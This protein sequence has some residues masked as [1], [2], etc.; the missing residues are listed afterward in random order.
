MDTTRFY[1]DLVRIPEKL[2]ALAGLVRAG[3]PGLDRL[4][5][6][7]RILIVAMGSSAYAAET[8]ARDARAAGM[9]VTVEL[10]SAT[11]LPK[12]APDLLVIAV[13]ATGGSVEVLAAAAPYAGTGRL[14]AITNRADSALA[15]LADH[16]VELAAGVEVSGISARTFRHTFIVLA[17]VLIAL[18]AEFSWSPAAVASASAEAN[19]ALMESRGEWL[20]PVSATLLGPSGTFV[21]SP[22]D[23][24]SSAKQSSLMLREVPRRPAWGS[25]TGDWSHVDVYLTKTL[26]YRAL[27]FAGSEW[28]DQAV[29]WMTERGSTLVAVG[30]D[31]D[32]ALHSIRYPGD[33]D[34]M[35]AALS[36]LLVAELVAWDWFCADPDYS[37]SEHTAR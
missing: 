33:Q 16:V 25:E 6:S 14:V 5:S 21:I 34:R 8:V 24:F 17:E 29:Q 15:T 26:D 32:Y 1:D 22:A 7:T 31:M 20:A 9:S 23:R 19:A 36:E 35:T 3:L 11:V 27:L 37:W 30:R 12:P 18:G 10:A 28:D 13:S 4:P 2:T